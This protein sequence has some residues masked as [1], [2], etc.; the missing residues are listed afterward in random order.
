MGFEAQAGCVLGRIW[1]KKRGRRGGEGD[2]GEEGGK[3][4]DCFS[5]KRRGKFVLTNEALRIQ[6]TE[7]RGK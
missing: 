7:E 5:L 6:I 3:K 2:K 4:K 1:K